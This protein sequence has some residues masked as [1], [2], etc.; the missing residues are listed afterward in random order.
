MCGIGDAMDSTFRASF[1]DRERV[2][3]PYADRVGPG[4]RPKLRLERFD[5]NHL[6]Q[7]RTLLSGS[8]P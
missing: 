2:P 3:Q 6:Q 4:V 8:K 5:E 1:G 7:G